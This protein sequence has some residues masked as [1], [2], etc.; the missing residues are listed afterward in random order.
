[1]TWKG[2]NHEAK[3]CC[4]H[5]YRSSERFSAFLVGYPQ[6]I[7]RQIGS[8]KPYLQWPDRLFGASPYEKMMQHKGTVVILYRIPPDDE[9]PY[10]NLFLPRTIA[11]VERNGW[12]MGDTGTGAYVAVY[13]IGRY[14]W[15]EIREAGS[16]R[17]MATNPNQI[18]G[19]L[20]RISDIN[21]GLVL[22][23]SEADCH[24]SFD[25]FCSKRAILQPDLDGWPKRDKVEVVTLDGDHLEIFYDGP[26]RVNGQEIDYDSYPLY[27]APGVHAPKGTGRMTFR[28]GPDEVHLDFGVDATKPLL[29]IRVIG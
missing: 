22:E 13:P 16:V 8:D 14:N 11:W 10:I 7:G 15:T 18:D 29:P 9:A 2:E 3:I 20:L 26:H 25:T 19:W 1:L 6:N 5:P 21:G 23:A 17:F 28:R 27:E 24:E 4:N 12:I